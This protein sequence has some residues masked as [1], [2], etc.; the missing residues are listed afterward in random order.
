M[1]GPLFYW[2]HTACSECS[3]IY[4]VVFVAF[5][6]CMCHTFTHFVT[7][8]THKSFKVTL[9]IH[10]WKSGLMLRFILWQKKNSHQNCFP[11]FLL[12]RYDT[13]THLSQMILMVRCRDNITTNFQHYKFCEVFILFRNNFWGQFYEDREWSNHFTFQGFC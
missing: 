12:L 11:Q 3:R 8:S 2:G 6:T 10:R 13:Y 4:S 5:F 1:L 9:N 7:L